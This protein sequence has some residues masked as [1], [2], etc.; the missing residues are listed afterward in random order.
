VVHRDS[1]RTLGSQEHDVSVQRTFPLRD[2]VHID[3]RA[4]CF[5][6]LNQGYT[7]TPGLTLT[8]NVKPA[9][10]SLGATTFGD[11]EPTIG[12]HRNLRFY[13]RIAF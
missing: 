1:F 4:E 10:G 8:S 12:G 6:V 5:N 13:M 9:D 3:F 7:G 11:F 2:S